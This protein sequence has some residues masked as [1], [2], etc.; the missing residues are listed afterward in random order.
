MHSFTRMHEEAG[1]LCSTA[2]DA[3]MLALPLAFPHECSQS[4]ILRIS[5][6]FSNPQYTENNF[7]GLLKIIAKY[8]VDKDIVCTLLVYLPSWAPLLSGRACLGD[9]DVDQFSS[10]NNVNRATRDS[11]HT[12]YVQVFAA[13]QETRTWDSASVNKVL[14]LMSN[15]GLPLNL[16]TLN[17]LLSREVSTLGESSFC[18]SMIKEPRI[19]K[20]ISPDSFTFGRIFLLYRIIRPQRV[21]KPRLP[22]SS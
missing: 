9:M 7:S 21:Q 2:F 10:L 14:D 6:I 3:K 5:L 4:I 20:K 12:P 22:I 16:P 8:E 1:L 19:S 13:L 15:G 11:M 18:H 17:I